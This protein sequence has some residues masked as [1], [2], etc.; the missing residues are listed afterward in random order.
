MATDDRERRRA[1][2]PAMRRDEPHEPRPGEGTERRE[3]PVKSTQGAELD[4]RDQGGI[5]E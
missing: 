2:N 3:E 4:P 5:A 1:V